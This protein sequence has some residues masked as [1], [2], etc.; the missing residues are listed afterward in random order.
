MLYTA[1]SEDKIEL[2]ALFNGPRRE[3]SKDVKGIT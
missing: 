2:N 3:G 1:P